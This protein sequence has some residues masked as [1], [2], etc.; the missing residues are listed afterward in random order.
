MSMFKA[1]N[2]KPFIGDNRVTLDAKH[3]EMT[4]Q[5][6]EMRKSLAEKRDELSVYQAKYNEL[7]KIPN[8]NLTNEQL[9]DKFAL[10]DS[11]SNLKTEISKIESGEEESKYFLETGHLLY[12]YYD[13]I[14]NIATKNQNLSDDDGFAL[15]VKKKKSAHTSGSSGSSGST[16]I[17][18]AASNAASSASIMDFF[19]L[20]DPPNQSKNIESH[21]VVIKDSKKAK[22]KN[23]EIKK[24]SDFVVTKENFQRADI[25]DN[26]L[27]I[28]DPTY[29]GNIKIDNQYDICKD[30][31]CER[32]VIQS[33]GIIVCE[34]CGNTDMIVI[35][36]DRPSYKDPPPKLFG[37]KSNQPSLC[38]Y[39]M[40]N[41]VNVLLKIYIKV[42]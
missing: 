12:K 29:I 34:Q 39:M 16:G 25:L 7:K 32:T 30:C 13:N 18:T 1:K 40:E 4:R 41:S 5:F 19:S 42:Y 26:Y 2:K 14:E 9:S 36:S 8:R 10:A 37:L 27:K 38:R 35:D 17:N 20:K 21:V 24:M 15:S 23:T 3:S 28:V 33:E 11:I 6:Q 22:K 31:N